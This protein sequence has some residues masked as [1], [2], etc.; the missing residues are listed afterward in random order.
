MKQMLTLLVVVIVLGG[1]IYIQQADT[2]PVKHVTVEGEFLHADKSALVAAVSPLVRGSFVDVDVAGVRQ[3]GEAL[4]WVKQVQVR[5][6]WPD[7]LHL[8]VE[9][10]IAVARWNKDGL[11][12]TTGAVFRPAV[13]TFPR[14]LVQLNGPAG[15]SEMMARRLVDF[16]QQVSP[17]ELRVTA[18]SMDQRRAWQVDFKDG[19]HLKLGRAESDSRLQRFIAV[20]GG[21]LERFKQQ[22]QQI[23]MRY[24]NGL[25]VIWKDGQQPDFNGT[26]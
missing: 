5:R 13:E 20:Y 3:A 4:P 22:I 14:G 15:T 11:V 12:N 6:I 16:Q 18:I 25:A 19:L 26:V 7:T 23:D 21:G 2:L 24:T 10:H 8:L 9:E 17:L 1:A